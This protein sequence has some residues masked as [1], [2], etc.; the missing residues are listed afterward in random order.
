MKSPVN[1]HEPLLFLDVDG[2][3]S[4][5]GFDPDERPAGTFHPI[6]GIPHYLSATVGEHLR[7]LAGHF[8]LVWCT[9]W[10]AKANEYLPAALGIP[11]PLE[12]LTFEEANPGGEGRHWKLAAIER[13]AGPHRPL[14]WIDDD[15][16]GCEA[17]AQARPGPTLLVTARPDVGLT[18]A[19]A[20]RLIDWA[21]GLQAAR[22]R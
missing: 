17:W 15:H 7:L 9:G 20:E 11:G 8:E 1:T 21:R 3:I 12:H 18:G 13:Y 2:V 22:R 5:F 16:R 10:E 6:D 4:L 14:A 19:E